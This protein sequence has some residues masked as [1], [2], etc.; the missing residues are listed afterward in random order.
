MEKRNLENKFNGNKLSNWKLNSKIETFN[1]G[2][3]RQS[4]VSIGFV[5][6]K[7]GYILSPKISA[8]PLEKANQECIGFTPRK[9]GYI[10][11]PKEVKIKNRSLGE[12]VHETILKTGLDYLAECAKMGEDVDE[13]ILSALGRAYDLRPDWYTDYQTK[14]KDAMKE[15]GLF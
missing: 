12:N 6:I 10:I 9:G 13:K 2:N 5:P 11:T 4:K 7:K 15:G 1:A 14:L 8:K 3:I